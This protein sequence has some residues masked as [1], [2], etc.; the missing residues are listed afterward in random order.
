M[1]AVTE[2]GAAGPLQA[3]PGVLRRLIRNRSA[4]SCQR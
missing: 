3:R 4:L 2:T 1:S